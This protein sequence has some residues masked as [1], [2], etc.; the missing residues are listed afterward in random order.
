MVEIT[1]LTPDGMEQAFDVRRRSFGS[2]FAFERWQRI[3]HE[4]IASGRALAAYDGGRVVAAARIVHLQQWWHGRAVPTAG[5]AGVVVAPEVRG[6]GVGRTLMAAILQRIGERRYPL[7][8]LYPATVPLYRSLGWELAGRQHFVELPA[9]A[10]RSFAAPARRVPVRR[11]E[12]GD[13]ERIRSV[14]G[15]VHQRHRHCGALEFQPGE[16]ERELED[17]DYFTYLADD[18]F[19]AY[20]F[21]DGNRRLDV[22]HLVAGSEETTRALW[23]LVGSGSSIASTVRACVAPDDPVVWLGREQQVD[24][25]EDLWWMLRLVDAEAAISGRGYPAGASAGVGLRIVDE[26]VPANSGDFLVEVSSGTATL[27]RA[28]PGPDPLVLAATG[29]AALYAGV[30]LATLRRCGLAHGGTGDD[31]A[32]LDGAFGATAFALDYF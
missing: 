1:E 19:V 18:G 26:A 3:Y 25:H 20:G 8:A 9:A 2:N 32:A 6:T 13:G 4:A 30:P 7:S 10:A 5:V 22:S 31:D 23:A 27:E 24:A 16:W 11:G 14:M 12:R 21:E 29:V 28:E 17:P 15:A